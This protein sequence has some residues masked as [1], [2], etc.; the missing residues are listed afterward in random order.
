MLEKNGAV[1]TMASARI[2]LAV[3]RNALSRR[4]GKG[5]AA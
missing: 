2:D 4:G 5:L 1:S 3:H